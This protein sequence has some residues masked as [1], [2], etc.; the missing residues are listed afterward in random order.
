MKLI[1]LLIAII[2][3]IGEIVTPTLTLIWF[4][5]G[6]FVLIFLSSF[7]DSILIQII[8]F[9]LISITLL[10]V[11]TKWIVKK[12][13][14]YEYNTNLKAILCKTGVVKKEILPNNTGIVV[15]ENEEWTSVSLDG[16]TIEQGCIVKVIKIEGVKLIVEKIK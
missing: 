12:D 8:I 2:F 7:I 3:A 16:E 15:V 11:V 5:I 13:E 10:V 6:A 14:T 4:S 9:A 1:W